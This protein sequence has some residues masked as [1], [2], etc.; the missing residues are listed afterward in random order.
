[1]GAPGIKELHEVVDQYRNKMAGSQYLLPRSSPTKEERREREIVIAA[2]RLG[3]IAF[4]FRQRARPSWL[5]RDS[6]QAVLRGT[7]KNPKHPANQMVG[8]W[9]KELPTHAA[10]Q[11]P[12]PLRGHQAHGDDHKPHRV[13]LGCERKGS[14]QA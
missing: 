1:M 2:A 14:M 8:P 4:T 7:R 12:T 9:K 13:Q 3:R 6:M 11:D 5:P 10:S